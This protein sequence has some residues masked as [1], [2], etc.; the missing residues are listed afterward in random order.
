MHICD[1]FKA[2][3]GSHLGSSWPP[4]LDDLGN[5]STKISWHM[6]CQMLPPYLMM[7]YPLLLPFSD[8][9]LRK[10]L[11]SNF[12]FFS[13]LLFQSNPEIG[14]RRTNGGKYT[15]RWVPSTNLLPEVPTSVSQISPAQ[16]DDE[17]LFWDP[18]RGQ[19]ITGENSGDQSESQKRVF[20]WLMYT[21]IMC[22]N[23]SGT[24]SSFGPLTLKWVMNRKN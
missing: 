22:V 20:C 23:A 8:V 12:L 17:T 11:P 19:N 2:H 24:D 15:E 21:Q 1:W 9:P 13:Y 6:V 5:A 16:R 18:P 7:C 3:L 14:K 10:P 4:S